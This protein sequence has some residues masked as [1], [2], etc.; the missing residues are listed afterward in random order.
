M[1][2]VFFLY[3][4]FYDIEKKHIG[5]G[6]IQTYLQ[7]L[8][9]I[10]LER[11]VKPYVYQ[12]SN[13]DFEIEINGISVCGV[14]VSKTRSYKSKKMQLLKSA[15]KKL[16]A[17]DDLLVFASE[18][19]L[20]PVKGIRTVCIQ[21]GVEWDK[22]TKRNWGVAAFC[23]SV[24]K[25][26]GQYRRLFA[27]SKA[28][29]LV[30]VDYN[31]VNWYRAAFPDLKINYRVILNFS[32]ILPIERE[33]DG[34]TSIIFARRFFEYRGTRVFA[35]AIKRVLEKYENLRVTVAG[36]GPD[37]KFLRSELEGDKRVT[38]TR[39]SADKS[40][41]IHGKHDIAVVPTLGSEGSSLSLI[42]AMSAGCAPVCTDVGGMTN[43]VINGIN[44]LMIRPDENDL[45]EALCSLIEDPQLRETIAENGKKT[46]LDALSYDRWKKQW[47]DVFEEFGVFKEKVQ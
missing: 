34:N 3:N 17:K 31:F 37:E 16:D 29:C 1:A 43:I 5:V 35:R 12:F 14:D 2:N 44:G 47:S 10:L 38:F 33:K 20:V 27:M 15:R 42:E 23:R 40:L 7:G 19:V 39:Y 4:N 45:F 36:E 18:S 24:Y 13:E 21:H 41:E 26:V 25:H 11:G 28:D 9:E 46:V 22:P 6:G 8:C 32:K 30:C